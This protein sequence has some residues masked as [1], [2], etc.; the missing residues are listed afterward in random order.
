ML[1]QSSSVVSTIMIEQTIRESD[2]QILQNLRRTETLF[3]LSV[4]ARGIRANKLIANSQFD[5]T[6]SQESEQVSATVGETAG[7][8]KCI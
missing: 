6:R 7:K 4:V 5:S 2:S 3:H 1:R 8:F